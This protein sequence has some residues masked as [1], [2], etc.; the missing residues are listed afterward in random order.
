VT[1]AAASNTVYDPAVNHDAT[2]SA[3]ALTLIRP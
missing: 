3:P 2:G 1:A